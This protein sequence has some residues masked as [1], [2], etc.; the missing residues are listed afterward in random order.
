VT[1]DELD[2]ACARLWA[3]LPMPVDDL[4]GMLAPAGL[5]I[6]NGLARVRDGMLTPLSVAE[7][8][9]RIAPDGDDG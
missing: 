7:Q 4:A 9:D 6:A 1:D 8:I 5:L 2:A 3:L